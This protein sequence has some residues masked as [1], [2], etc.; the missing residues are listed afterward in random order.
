VLKSCLILPSFQTFTITTKTIIFKLSSLLQ[1]LK[2]LV[3]NATLIYLF[4]FHGC[5]YVQCSK[6]YISLLGVC[7]VDGLEDGWKL[8]C[9]EDELL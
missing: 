7:V 6:T 2:Y 3:A 9:S 4:L 1:L 8:V 5:R